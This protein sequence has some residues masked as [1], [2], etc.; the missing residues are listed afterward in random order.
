MKFKPELIYYPESEVRGAG[1]SE[2][3]Y[4]PDWYSPARVSRPVVQG[5]GTIFSRNNR[6]GPE[7][8]RNGRN[9]VLRRIHSQCIREA[10]TQ[11]RTAYEREL[12]GLLELDPSQV[13]R[14]MHVGYIRN[15]GVDH[16]AIPYVDV[17]V[18]RQFG[19]EV[20]I[21]PITY[22][23]S[24]PHDA[25]ER[26]QR[27][28]SGSETKTEGSGQCFSLRTKVKSVSPSTKKQREKQSK[29]VCPSEKDMKKLN[30]LKEPPPPKDSF[31]LK[32][33]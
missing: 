14:P 6:V 32:M 4:R 8:D 15:R 23:V 2:F 27:R 28:Y 20:S 10:E 13:E 7:P 19:N 22:R 16:N 18:E 30:S 5:S 17:I 11:D 12:N 3:R 26:L 29:A 21:H 9:A 33:D 1:H 24:F 31:I 25:I